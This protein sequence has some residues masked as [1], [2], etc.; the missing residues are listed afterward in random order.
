MGLPVSDYCCYRVGHGGT[1]TNEMVC[2][3][4]TPSHNNPMRLQVAM[5]IFRQLKCNSLVLSI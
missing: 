4:C 1:M 3:G 2:S 5:F